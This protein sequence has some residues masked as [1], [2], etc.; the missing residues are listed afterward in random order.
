MV[1]YSS[2]GFEYDVSWDNQE[3]FIVVPQDKKVVDL[4]E[5]DL[6]DMLAVLRDKKEM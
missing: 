4:T 5:E 3:V 6:W 2:Y 1:N